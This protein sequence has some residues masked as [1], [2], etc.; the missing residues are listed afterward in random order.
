MHGLGWLV[1]CQRCLSPGPACAVLAPQRALGEP[2]SRVSADFDN[3]HAGLCEQDMTMA[4]CA[5]KPRPHPPSGASSGCA[6]SAVTCWLQPAACCRRAVCV[7]LNCLKSLG[8]FATA[9]TS[10]SARRSLVE[11]PM[12]DC[13]SAT[14][15][16]RSSPVGRAAD[17]VRDWRMVILTNTHFHHNGVLRCAI[18]EVYFDGSLFWPMIEPLVF[19]FGRRSSGTCWRSQETHASA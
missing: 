3:S 7:L 9:M 6:S 4:T 19:R 17:L 13:R 14:A 18:S 10:A 5:H 1:V 8:R 16:R 2:R 15:G 11:Q 12:P